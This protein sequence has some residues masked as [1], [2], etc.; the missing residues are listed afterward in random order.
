[1]AGGA[2]LVAAEIAALAVYRHVSVIWLVTAPVLVTLAAVFGGLFLWD[3]NISQLDLAINAVEI[4]SVVAAGSVA[5]LS[6]LTWF[7]VRPPGRRPKLLGSLTIALAAVAA[8]LGAVR[9]WHVM[10]A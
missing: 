3:Q 1:M 7:M 10:M 5:L 4:Q 9:L 2:A 6:V 8:M